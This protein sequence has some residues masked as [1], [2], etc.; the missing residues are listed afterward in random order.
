[1]NNNM[2]LTE[3][4]KNISFLLVFMIAQSV[5]AESFRVHELFPVTIYDTQTTEQ[6]IT[7]GINDSIAIFLPD[8]LIY[9]EGIELQMQIPDA[10]AQWRDSVVCS[11]YDDI[12]PVPSGDRIDY[13]GTRIFIATLPM[14]TSWAMQIPLKKN[15]SIRETAFAKKVD[16]LPKN[17]GKFIFVRIQPAMKGIPNET[18][19]AKIKISVKPIL[20]NKGKFVLDVN[21]PDGKMYTILLDDRQVSDEISGSFI[22]AGQH[23]VSIVSE[24]YR[25]ETRTI[26]VEQGKTTNLSVSLR[27]V[28]PTIFISAPDNANVFLDG[29]IF[30][31]LDREIQISEGPHK[32][33]FKTDSYEVTKEIFAQSGKSYTASLLMDIQITED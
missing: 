23:T 7:V 17:S 30:T 11:I 9:C 33:R 15:N 2:N 5:Y 4:A 12:T 22:D 14:R 10:V 13:N 25:N 1:M 26:R 16:V 3:K 18:L 21:A 20:L 27:S 8:E 32:I 24:H 29:E 28:E 19:E 6:T 31:E